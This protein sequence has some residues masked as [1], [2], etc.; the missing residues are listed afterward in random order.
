MSPVVDLAAVPECHDDD[1]ENIVGNSVNDAV[2][3][4][5]NTQTGA[6]LQSARGGWTRILRQ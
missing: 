5:P 3:T 2:I 6:A 1:E 4:D